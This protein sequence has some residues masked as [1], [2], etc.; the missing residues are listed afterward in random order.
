MSIEPEVSMI[1]ISAA[2]A[3][4]LPAVPAPVHVTETTAC[5]SVAPSDRNSF[6]NVLAV[7][8]AIVMRVLSPRSGRPGRARP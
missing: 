7:K 5:T 4:P 2:S 8:S 3:V 1:N 6:W